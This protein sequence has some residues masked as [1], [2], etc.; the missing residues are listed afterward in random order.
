M[1]IRRQYTPLITP[2]SLGK[3]FVSGYSYCNGNITF[4]VGYSVTGG[5]FYSL[6]DIDFVQTELRLSL[7]AMYTD[8]GRRKT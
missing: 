6:H 1:V 5:N 7:M 8:T 4:C 2:Y 3:G